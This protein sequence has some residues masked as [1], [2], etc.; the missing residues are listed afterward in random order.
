MGTFEIGDVLGFR[1]GHVVGTSPI[2]SLR[3]DEELGVAACSG[4][5]VWPGVHW[6]GYC[7]PGTREPA[8]HIG[9][10]RRDDH[11]V[12][13]V[14]CCVCLYTYGEMKRGDSEMKRGLRYFAFSFAG[15]RVEGSAPHNRLCY[16]DQKGTFET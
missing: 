9:E 4:P 10:G 5:S 12:M 14:P 15:K 2:P 11:G 13:C 1:P 3:A 7:R 8:G 16:A 6:T